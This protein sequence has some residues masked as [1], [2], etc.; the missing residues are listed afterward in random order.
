M[1]ADPI[2]T[3]VLARPMPGRPSALRGF[4]AYRPARVVENAEIT[5]HLGI[6]PDWVRSRTGIERRGR[7]A[8][9]ETIVEM[10][11]RAGTRALARAGV[12]ADDLGSVL[13]ATMTNIRQVPCLAPAVA[14]ELGASRAGGYDVNAA[15]GG[16]S[17]ALTAA[18]GHIAAGHADHVLVVAAER[19][20]D[21]I[22]AG[23]RGT[24]ALFGDGA[25]AAVVSAADRPGFGPVVWGTEG[26]AE[27]L[28]TLAPDLTG[29]RDEHVTRPRARMRGQA[30]YLWASTAPAPIV[31]EAMRAAGVSWNDVAAFVPHQANARITRALVDALRPPP[32]VVVADSVRHDGNTGAASIPLAIERLLSTERVRSGDLAVL[33]GFG[34]GLTW[35]AQVVRLP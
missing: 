17:L 11:F 18:T 8:A 4:G 30:L 19:T 13:L 2:P 32:H 35:A 3:G 34:V 24:S 25:A 12:K 14:R 31:E 15:C 16:F 9:D 10:A 29:S 23:D 1:T 27:D 33:M 26:T 21:I 20:S 7:A 22:D 6:T 5:D 28:F